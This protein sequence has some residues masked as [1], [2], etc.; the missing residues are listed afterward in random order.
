M[1]I[2]DDALFRE[3]ATIFIPKLINEIDVLLEEMSYICKQEQ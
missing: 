2:K 1:K 3:Y